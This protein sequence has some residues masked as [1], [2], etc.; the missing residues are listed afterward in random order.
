M[1]TPTNAPVHVHNERGSTIDLRGSAWQVFRI[2]AEFVEGYQFLT[3][4][5]RPVTVMG[6]ARTSPDSPY[7]Q[8]A[9]K[10]GALLGSEKYSVV[11]GGG[12]GIMEAANKGAKESGGVSAGINIQLPHEQ[13]LNPYVQFSR[14]CYYF[15]T[16]KVLLTA[17]AQAFVIFPGGFGTLDELFEVLD[18][19][20]NGQLLR[21]PVI[22]VVS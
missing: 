7:Y 9:V 3:Q 11:T 8:E 1:T 22:F 18:Q 4:F 21:V 17:P 5:T 10:M 16:R 14:G 15:L 13:H 2:M 6:S 20:R 19:I 12:P